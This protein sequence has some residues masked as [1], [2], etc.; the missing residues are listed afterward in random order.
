MQSSKQCALPVITTMA[1]W[2]PMHLGVLKCMGCHKA[3]VVIT[4]RAHCFHDC[5]YANYA[6]LYMNYAHL[7]SV[8]FEHSVCC[9]SLIYI[10]IYIYIYMYVCMYV[11]IYDMCIYIYIYMYI[12][13]VICIIL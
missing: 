9:G 10:Y 1:L 11:Y 2:Q 5:I 3:I 4:G 7:A 6:N 12:K 8:G 13:C